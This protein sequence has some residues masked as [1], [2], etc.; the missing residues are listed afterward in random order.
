MFCWNC[1]TQTRDDASFCPKCGKPQKQGGD[2]AAININVTS[3]DVWETCEINLVYAK[4][5]VGTMPEW[6]LTRKEW[7]F[8]ATA[9]GT[10]G[11]Y[12]AALSE[13]LFLIS[14]V[15]VDNYTKE[16]YPKENARPKLDAM[17]RKLVD[18]GWQPIG[19]GEKWYGERFRRLVK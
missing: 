2:V 18:D 16:V 10:Q 6:L 13:Q 17:I 19:R 9:I 3:D 5:Q 12:V 8:E 14:E 11:R 4:L 7:Y 1:G 15:A